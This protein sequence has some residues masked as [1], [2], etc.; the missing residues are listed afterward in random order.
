MASSACCRADS[1]AIERGSVALANMRL[2]EWLN[3]RLMIGMLAKLAMNARGISLRG[4][5]AER[6]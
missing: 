1:M 6:E 4:L 5:R 3:V 2:A